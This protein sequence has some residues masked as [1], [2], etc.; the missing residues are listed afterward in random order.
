M[1]PAIVDALP[2]LV[3]SPVRFALVVTAPAVKL[4]AVPD[5]FVATPLAGVPNAGV[6]NVGLVANA[7]APLP[8]SSEIVPASSADVVAAK[9]LRFAPDPATPDSAKV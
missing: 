6:T 5:K 9:S 1:L 8:V 4:A 3:T 2:E 7:S